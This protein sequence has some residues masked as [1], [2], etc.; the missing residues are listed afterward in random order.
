MLV[1][2][3]KDTNYAAAA[4]A[5]FESIIEEGKAASFTPKESAHRRGAFPAINVGVTHGKGTLAPVYLNNN[6]H[7]Q[8]IER[9]LENPS[10]QRL[11]TF[12]SC[13]FA[14]CASLLTFHSFLT[15]SFAAWA[16]NVYK[17]YQDRLTPLF[18]HAPHLCRIFRKSIYPA[19]AF[20]FGP[21]VWTFKHK[22]TQNCP[23]GWCAIQA[24][25]R[26]DP[27]KGGH[28]VLWE[29]KLIAEFPPGSLVLIP[30]ATLTHSNIPV[31][32]GDC[33]ASFTQYCAGGLFRYVDYGFRRDKQLKKE[34]PTL[35]SD[36]CK[37]RPQKWQEGLALLSTLK[38]FQ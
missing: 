21:N 13:E 11:A 23:F 10:L 36:L 12:A 37:L 20:N 35:H 19:A 29:L 25:G 27:K 32:D 4:D 16:P 24:L 38:D 9:L 28:L 22:D 6:R 2:Q 26:F 15:A 31:A 5:A 8:M 18:E 1:G 3:P 14:T 7:A 30:S 33:R 34:D 17:Y